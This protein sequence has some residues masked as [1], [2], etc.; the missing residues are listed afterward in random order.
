MTRNCGLRPAENN[1]LFFVSIISA[2]GV[3]TLGALLDVEAAGLSAHQ[4]G[5]FRAVDILLT[6]GGPATYQSPAVSPDGSRI[7]FSSNRD[8]D[9]DIYAMN[10]E[11]TKRH[12]VKF[13]SEKIVVFGF[14]FDKSL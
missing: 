8:G 2:V 4:A 10:R 11:M 12:L 6:L 13:Q 3:R 5:A 7:A 14:Q 9:F 1:R